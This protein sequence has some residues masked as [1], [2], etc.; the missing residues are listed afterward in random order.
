[1]TA[2]IAYTPKRLAVPSI[3]LR[4]KEH[5]NIDLRRV[6]SDSPYDSTGDTRSSE[7][8]ALTY[9]KLFDCS[10]SNSFRISRCYCPTTEDIVLRHTRKEI[11][12]TTPESAPPSGIKN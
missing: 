9:E 3:D 8:S 4:L 10:E 11:Y 5:Q 1:M 7:Q 2:T 12:S 6:L